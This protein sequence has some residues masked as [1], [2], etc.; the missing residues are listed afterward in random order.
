MKLLVGILIFIWLLCGVVGAWRLDKLDSDH[1]KDVG[2]GP[3]TLAE[4]FA[5]NPVTYPGP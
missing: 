1:W 2:R 4:S 5:D 3:V